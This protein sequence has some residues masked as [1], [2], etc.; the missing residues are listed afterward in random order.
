MQQYVVDMYIKL[1]TS[2][3]D[4]F[5]YNQQHIR[6]ELYLG[7]INSVEVGENRAS[8]IGH[9]VILSSSLIGE[10]RDTRKRYMDAMA[11]VQCFGKPDIFLTMTCNP[12]WFSNSSWARFRRFKTVLTWSHESLGQN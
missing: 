9:Q 12:N 6:S 10:P 5:R 7:I 4:Y 1:E 11:L 3:L 8:K 2:R